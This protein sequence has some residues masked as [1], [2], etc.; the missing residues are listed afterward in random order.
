MV[1]GVLIVQAMLPVRPPPPFCF[2]VNLY[3]MLS[4]FYVLVYSKIMNSKVGNHVVTVSD[5]HSYQATFA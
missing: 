5:H 3:P 4:S 1:V 2:S